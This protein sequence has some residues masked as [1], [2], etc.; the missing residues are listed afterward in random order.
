MILVVPYYQGVENDLYFYFTAQTDTI[1]ANYSSNRCLH[2]KYHTID[3]ICPTPY[4]TLVTVT[5]HE[6]E[7]TCNHKAVYVLFELKGVFFP[8]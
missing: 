7:H 6:L 8:I 3:V 1:H 5:L 2:C 4:L